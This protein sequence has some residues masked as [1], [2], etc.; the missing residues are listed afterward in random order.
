MAVR[1]A[2]YFLADKSCATYIRVW[3]KIVELVKRAP[4][5]VLLDFESANIKAVRDVLSDTTLGGCYFH[6]TQANYRK[7]VALGFRQTYM[8]DEGFRHRFKSLMTMGF[9]H[10]SHVA[11][12]FH[13]LVTPWPDEEPPIVDYFEFS[14]LGWYGEKNVFSTPFR[15]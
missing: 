2:F 12:V 15:S 7:I 10:V 5:L 11:E 3:S 14:W 9:L 6:F 8:Q 1:V 4:A 13:A